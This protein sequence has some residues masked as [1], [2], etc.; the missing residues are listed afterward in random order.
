MAIF[1]EMTEF[2]KGIYVQIKFNSFYHRDIKLRA[3]GPNNSQHCWPGIVGTCWVCVGS[4]VQTDATT[5]SERCW[6]DNVR[7]SCVRLQV[8]DRLTGF[9]LYATTPNNM[10]QGVQTDAKCNIQHCWEFLA[11]N[12]ASV[13]TGLN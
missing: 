4:G 1:D 7:T 13:C 10:Q 3:N 5:D 2:S 9:K 6:P 8:V 12:V 11:N